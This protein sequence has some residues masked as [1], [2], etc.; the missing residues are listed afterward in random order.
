MRG[1]ELLKIFKRFL[2]SRA[3]LGN[4]MSGVS[5][6]GTSFDA[7]DVIVNNYFTKSLKYV[8]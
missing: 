8:G 7:G 1:K 4:N 5:H 2:N 6:V 3:L